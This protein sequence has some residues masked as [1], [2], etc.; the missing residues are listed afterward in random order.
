M[1]VPAAPKGRLA[2]MLQ[3]V[4][5]SS[6]VDCGWQVKNAE[7]GGQ[8]ISVKLVKD[9]WAKPCNRTACLVCRSA[10]ARPD[11]KSVA[12]AFRTRG[13][14]TIPRNAGDIDKVVGRGK[15]ANDFVR[16]RTVGAKRIHPRTRPLRIGQKTTD[17]QRPRQESG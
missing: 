13:P 1:F 17:Q 15:Q 9:F 10:E 7:R 5:E 14:D 4:D 11:R 6:G 16:H 2:N 12:T 8:E 3:E